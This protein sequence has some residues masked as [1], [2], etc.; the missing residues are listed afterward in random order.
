LRLSTERTVQFNFDTVNLF[1]ALAIIA[2]FMQICYSVENPFTHLG[3][4]I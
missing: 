4:L 3:A 2:K 1:P